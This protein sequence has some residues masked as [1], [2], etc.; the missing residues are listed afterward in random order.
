[1]QKNMQKVCDALEKKTCKIHNRKPTAKVNGSKIEIN[2][3]C[4]KFHKELK[5]LM[6]IELDKQIYNNM[7]L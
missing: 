6:D 2:A 4:N 5:R 7:M 1:M 3:C